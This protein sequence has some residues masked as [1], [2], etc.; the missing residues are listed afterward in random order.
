MQ[1]TITVSDCEIN[2]EI[3]SII[4]AAV[5]ERVNSEVAGYFSDTDFN[6]IADVIAKR[7]ADKIHWGFNNPHTSDDICR[8]ISR[9][10]DERLVD[11]VKGIDDKQFRDVL[12]AHCLQ[13][14]CKE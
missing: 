4:S 6:G 12:F 5:T 14:F 13:R 1:F 8:T 9:L 3:Q 2:Q 7:L 10:L 11:I